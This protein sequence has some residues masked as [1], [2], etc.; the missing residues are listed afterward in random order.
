M[1]GEAQS[2]VINDSTTAFIPNN[3]PVL[4][5]GLTFPYLEKLVHGSIATVKSNNVLYLCPI[6][7]K[8]IFI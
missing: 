7:P 8:E 5:K 3:T 2:G 4:I 1:R 6:S